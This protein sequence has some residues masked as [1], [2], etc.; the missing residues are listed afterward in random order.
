MTD[1]CQS[2][3]IQSNPIQSYADDNLW[4]ETSAEKREM[5]RLQWDGANDVRKAAEVS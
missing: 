3:P 4:R 1:E 5:E 2:N